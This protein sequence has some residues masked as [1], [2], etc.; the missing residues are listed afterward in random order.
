MADDF[1][2]ETYL[3]LIEMIGLEK[4]K[5][6]IDQLLK[7]LIVAQ[8]DLT[9]AQ[10]KKSMELLDKCTHVISSLAGT[11]GVN[12]IHQLAR[13]VNDQATVRN[14]PFPKEDVDILL[15]GLKPWVNFLTSE[16]QKTGSEA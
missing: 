7:D 9:K 11:V 12:K 2:N 1:K 13:D 8:R 15:A 5:V 4:S 10:S 3:G 14:A 16:T 6:L